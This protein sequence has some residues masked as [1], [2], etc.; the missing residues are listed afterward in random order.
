MKNNG[1]QTILDGTSKA[2]AEQLMN[3]EQLQA[4]QEFLQAKAYQA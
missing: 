2:K 1:A 3:D 4:F